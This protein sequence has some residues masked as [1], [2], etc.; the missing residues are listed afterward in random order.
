MSV[1]YFHEW[2][3]VTSEMAQ[4]VQGRINAQT[5]DAPPEG[6][7][8]HAD[9]ESDGNWWGFDVW[10]SEDAAQRFFDEIIGPALDAQGIPRSQPRLLPIHW[11]S[12]EAPTTAG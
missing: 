9:G 1:A 3:G 5:G 6:G 8:F 4:G 11:Q 2:P 12:L 10:E 7:I